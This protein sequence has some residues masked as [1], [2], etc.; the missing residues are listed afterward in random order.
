MA[1]DMPVALPEN[2]EPKAPDE[3]Q[4]QAAA[5]PPPPPPRVTT[6][7]TSTAA[8]A[9]PGT[10][11]TP[12]TPIRTISPAPLASP[13]LT[14]LVS[15]PSVSSISSA[16]LSSSSSAGAGSPLM[17]SATVAGIS[18]VSVG[19]ISSPSSTQ[20]SGSADDAAGHG[21]RGHQRAVSIMDIK[22][23]AAPKPL[24]PRVVKPVVYVVDELGPGWK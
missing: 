22:P 12:R 5:E 24:P 16:A 10:L 8:A 20:L 21:R 17:R 3:D 18:A 6:A 11:S 9:T 23:P 15:S 1:G 13:S 7:A 4:P 2:D 19:L 14:G